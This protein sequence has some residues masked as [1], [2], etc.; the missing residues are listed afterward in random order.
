MNTFD[1]YETVSDYYSNFDSNIEEFKSFGSRSKSSSRSNSPSSRTR[2]SHSSSP[3]S[4]P[5]FLQQKTFSSSK[6]YSQPIN[7]SKINYK[8][9]AL[10]TNK[11]DIPLSKNNITQPKISG[12][13]LKPNPRYQK[14]NTNAN[15]NTNANTNSNSNSNAMK[16]GLVGVGL[17]GTR[18]SK[19]Y[20][21][22]KNHIKTSTSTDISSTNDLSSK[23]KT[24]NDSKIDINRKKEDQS[25]LVISSNI[26]STYDDILAHTKNKIENQRWNNYDDKNYSNRYNR[27]K[28][29]YYWN[30]GWK[31]RSGYW[32]NGYWN[33]GYWYY[34][35]YLFY[36]YFGYPYQY[37][38][39]GMEYYYLEY[40]Y[41]N[42][43]ITNIDQSQ[44]DEIEN[45]I[46]N[47]D[48]NQNEEENN[49]EEFNK[50]LLDELIKLKIRL[51][52]LEKYKQEKETEIKNETNLEKNL[53]SQVKSEIQNLDNLEDISEEI[54]KFLGMKIKEETNK[55][56]ET[57]EKSLIE[58]FSCR[59]S[60]GFPY[61]IVVIL[62]ILVF[63]LRK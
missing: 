4:R 45:K 51:G 62:I 49:S 31:Y 10:T 11:L 58:N 9:G 34:N 3:S 38:Y 44:L 59:V 28:N 17:V 37:P 61:F 50:F 43:P 29:K 47:I 55:T 48:T 27:W 63:V 22:D 16:A 19:K 54:I 52:E 26:Q 30:R 18:L 5:S 46:D 14:K 12:I 1:N 36:S 21:I 33:D 7:P 6:Q 39:S 23:I 13:P 32:D 41:L 25:K 57:N 56:N 40:P 42:Y 20:N 8:G 2:S 60:F 24:S 15:A 53:I 35:P